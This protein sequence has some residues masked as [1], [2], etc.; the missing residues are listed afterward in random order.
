MLGT[1]NP[2]DVDSVEQHRELGR[3][4]LDRTT[5]TGDARRAKAALF[6]PLVI[7]NQP[8]TI[9]EQDLAAV[10]A[11]PKKHEQV[12]GEE[13]HAPLSADDAAQA[14]VA[15]AKVDGLDSEVD[16]NTR[17]QREQRLPQPADHGC[18]VSGIAALLE[19]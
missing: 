4:H 5:V 11:T 8:A 6:Q 3:V 17:R 7:E 14:I 1:A 16:P 2:T 10:P 9:P 15:T 19:A 18:H 13:V 12:S